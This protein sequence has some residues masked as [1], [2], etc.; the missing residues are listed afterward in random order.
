MSGYG[1]GYFRDAIGSFI[2]YFRSLL[3]SVLMSS[4]PDSPTTVSPTHLHDADGLY[5]QCHA[6]HGV[7]ERHALQ[8]LARV[9]W[10]RG[11]GE[12]GGEVVR[13]GGGKL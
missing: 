4:P 8:E 6:D 13:E 10:G 1:C 9:L 5:E 7:D 11:R 2:I 3:H 12:G